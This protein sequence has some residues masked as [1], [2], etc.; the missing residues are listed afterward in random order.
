MNHTQD[1]KV[2]R[3]VSTK[4][5]QDEFVRLELIGPYLQ[6]RGYISKANTSEAVRF[7]LRASVEWTFTLMNHQKAMNNIT[8][9]SIAS[10]SRNPVM[11]APGKISTTT[12]DKTGDNVQRSSC[13][14]SITSVR[15]S[16]QQSGT[17][18]GNNNEILTS[19]VPT[20]HYNISL[21]QKVRAGSINIRNQRGKHIQ[22]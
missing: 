14:G 3:V 17:I 2:R 6:R 19:D 7:L 20:G 10:E 13:D 4:I 15:S 9:Q 22:H 18:L 5:T 12:L 11:I 16:A 21:S 8:T 1:T